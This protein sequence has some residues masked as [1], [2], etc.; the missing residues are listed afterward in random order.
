MRKIFGE[1]RRSTPGISSESDKVCSPT[2]PDRN[3]KV[4]TS[5]SK[6]LLE[7]WTVLVGLQDRE[8][9]R[10]VSLCS[11]RSLRA[12]MCQLFKIH[13]A[14]GECQERT[15]CND[16]HRLAIERQCEFVGGR[17]RSRRI[18]RPIHGW[19]RSVSRDVIRR[20]VLRF[21]FSVTLKYINATINFCICF[22]FK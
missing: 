12:S 14:R 1:D 3:L 22:F 18:S 6:G 21:Y 16:L 5:F 7:Y 11:L 17:P 10:S 13:K 19:E 4:V 9:R 8:E 15:K 20:R 2:L